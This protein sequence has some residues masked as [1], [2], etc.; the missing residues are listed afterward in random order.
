MEL[1]YGSKGGF[2]GYFRAWLKM[3][4]KFWA[5]RSSSGRGNPPTVDLIALP[6]KKK[7]KKRNRNR[8]RKKNTSDG[9]LPQTQT[10]L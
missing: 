7:K 3:L 2:R 1:A 8:K 5:L 4:A 10:Q 6:K 9:P